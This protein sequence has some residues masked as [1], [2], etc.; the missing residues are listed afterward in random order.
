MCCEIKCQT[1]GKISDDVK[2]VMSTIEFEQ[3]GERISINL[4]DACEAA[5]LD[6]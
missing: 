6:T 3:T 5:M 4:C 2:P 1:C